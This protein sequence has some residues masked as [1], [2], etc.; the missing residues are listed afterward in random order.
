M[1]RA[2]VLHSDTPEQPLGGDQA[3]RLRE[4]VGSLDK[5][6]GHLLSQNHHP[7]HHTPPQRKIPVIAIASGKG[8][9]GKTTTSVNLAIALASQNR[10]TGAATPMRSNRRRSKATVARAT[11]QH[12]TSSQVRLPL[13]TKGSNRKPRCRPSAADTLLTS[14]SAGG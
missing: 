8:G 14:C 2:F 12:P 13:A 3:S 11:S 9:V 4:L 5:G 6:D 1:T 10:R 7:N